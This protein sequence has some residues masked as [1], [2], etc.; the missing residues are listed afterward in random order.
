MGAVVSL[1]TAP[2]SMAATCCGSL[3]G[4]CAASM[5]CKACSCSCVASN[6]VTSAIYIVILM[7]FV[8]TAWLFKTEG[9][10]IVIG[11]GSNTTEASILDRAASIAGAGALHY[12]NDRFYC[13]PAHPH[14]IAIICCA[15]TCGGVFAVYRFSFVLCL[16]FAFLLCDLPPLT[17]SHHLSPLPICFL[18]PSMIHAYAYASSS[19]SPLR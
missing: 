13:A 6:R 18:P 7:T 2:L 17:R 12:W 1:A 19:L 3:F 9:G 16:F 11:G 5:L 15:N 8:G 14:A 10:D 4:S